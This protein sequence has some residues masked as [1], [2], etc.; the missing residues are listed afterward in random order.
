MALAP[1][2]R[3]VSNAAP[4]TP[5]DMALNI[6]RLTSRCRMLSGE[7]AD[8]MVTIDQVDVASLEAAAKLLHELE[9]IWPEVR[10]GIIARNILA[11]RRQRS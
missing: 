4:L 2:L 7:I 5:Y 11:K 1:R 3:A 6:D 9:F 10:A 8:A